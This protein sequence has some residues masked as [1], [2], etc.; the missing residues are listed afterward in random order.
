[1]TAWTVPVSRLPKPAPCPQ[2][3]LCQRIAEQHQARCLFVTWRHSIL[4]SCGFFRIT[5]TP[6]RTHPRQPPARTPVNHPRPP[7]PSMLSVSPSGVEAG[8]EPL[9]LEYRGTDRGARGRMRR[10]E[11]RQER[12]KQAGREANRARGERGRGG[13]MARGRE[14]ARGREREM[15]REREG[16]RDLA[17]EGLE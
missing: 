9:V 2:H 7:T 8:H 5:C 4:N 17:V 16:R 12:R 13:E 10:Q 3:I 6:P 11:R 15:E 1:M 14:V